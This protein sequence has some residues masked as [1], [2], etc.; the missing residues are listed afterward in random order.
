[1]SRTTRLTI[2]V[3]GL[4]SL[5]GIT[6]A[7]AGAVTWHNTGSTNFT[8]TAGPVSLSST[9][10]QWN[11]TG[12]TATG[13]APA[14]AS[15]G[16]LYNIRGTLTFS[17]CSL[18]GINTGIDCAFA[19]TGA[20]QPAAGQTTGDLD[21]TCRMYQFNAQICHIGGSLH[22]FYTNPVSGVGVLTTTTGGN[23]VTTDVPSAGGSCPLGT[24]RV[25]VSEWTLRTTSATP[26]IITR[27]A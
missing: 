3:V 10:T 25:H 6:S 12:A 9:G 5:F 20:T 17:G 26:P 27:T 14:G 21:L 16:A 11:C 24:D 23:L 7:T 4:L 15:V 1:M 8:A 22:T 19:L 13:D 18:S 2:A